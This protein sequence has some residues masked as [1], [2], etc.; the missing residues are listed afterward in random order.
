MTST[1]ATTPTSIGTGER[2]VSR[3]IVVAATPAEVFALLTDPREHPALDGSGTVKALVD[4][5]AR[6]TAGSV[7]RMKM[8][9]YTTENRVVE[10]VPDAVIAWRHRARHVWRWELRAVA[11]GTEVTETFDHTAKRCPGVV[12]ALGVPKRAGAAIDATLRRLQARFA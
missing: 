6:L 10:F 3:R 7:F 8:S 11:G 4:G 1:H 12:A 5:P 9:G 2:R